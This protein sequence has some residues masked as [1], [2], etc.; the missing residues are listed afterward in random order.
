M[1]ITKGTPSMKDIYS[2]VATQ[3]TGLR[4]PCNKC[5]GLNLTEAIIGERTVSIT[6]ETTYQPCHVCNGVGWLSTHDLQNI[7]MNIEYN[8]TLVLQHDMIGWMAKVTLD[9]EAKDWLDHE[10]PVYGDPVTAVYAALYRSI[11]KSSRS[12]AATTTPKQALHTNL[13]V[14]R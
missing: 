14:S 10:R 6:S 5:N 12:T 4:E 3:M 11:T 7:I 2:A 9:G 8:F 13:D 1:T